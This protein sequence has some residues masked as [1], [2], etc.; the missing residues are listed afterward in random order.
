MSPGGKE[1]TCWIRLEDVVFNRRL[2]CRGADAGLCPDVEVE[3]SGVM[4]G[5]CA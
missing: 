5:L 2:W 1:A 3:V 4:A